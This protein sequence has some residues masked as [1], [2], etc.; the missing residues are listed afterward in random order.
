MSWPG[1]GGPAVLDRPTPARGG[2]LRRPW[3]RR[4]RVVAVL[5]GLVVLA[6]LAGVG[7]LALYSRVLDVRTI[8]VRGAGPGPGQVLPA[9]VRRAAAVPT[10]G[11]LARLDT[12]AVAGRVL[13]LP[14]VADVAVSRHVPHTVRLVVTE[15]VPV[16]VLSSSDGQRRL[17]DA[18]GAVWAPAGA[19][20][21]GLPVLVDRNGT[22]D[23]ATVTAAVAVSTTLPGDLRSRV[24][25]LLAP[26][27]DQVAL[28]LGDG[29]VVVWGDGGAADRKARVATALLGATRARYLDVSVPDAPVTRSSLPAGLVPGG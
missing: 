23:A 4:R 11:P 28:V 2:A 16:A 8:Q 22:M 7:W 1:R 3:W 5:A 25:E 6:V 17:V 29:R 12:R 21:S 18:S 26:S 9:T 19:F 20:P 10:G 15:R 13:Q 24:R 27:A 14:G